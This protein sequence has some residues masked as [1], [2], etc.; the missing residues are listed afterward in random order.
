[1]E[2][3]TQCVCMGVC[4]CYLNTFLRL[5]VSVMFFGISGEDEV[6]VAQ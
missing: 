2:V 4:V 6:A 1:M 5:N 3:K